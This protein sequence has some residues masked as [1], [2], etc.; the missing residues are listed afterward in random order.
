MTLCDVCQEYT[1]DQFLDEASIEHR[2]FGELFSTSKDCVLCRLILKT[3]RQRVAEST[4]SEEEIEK[5]LATLNTSRISLR[6]PA[7][8][9]TKSPRDRLYIDFNGPRLMIDGWLVLSASDTSLRLIREPGEHYLEF[10]RTLLTLVI[11]GSPQVRDTNIPEGQPLELNAASDSLKK[12]ISGWLEECNQLHKECHESSA[13]EGEVSGKLPV[14]VLDLGLPHDRCEPRLL[15]EH[16]FSSPYVALSHCW[17]LSR[18]IV[19]DTTNLELH[20]TR[21]PYSCLPKTFQDAILLTKSIGIRY[22]WIDSLCI[23]QDNIQDW[24]NEAAKMA[25]VYGNAYCTIAATG[26]HGD[27]E[28]VFIPRA[29]Q[30]VCNLKYGESNTKILVTSI[31]DDIS[32]LK[33]LH[34]DSPL[35]NR[36]WTLQEKLLSR[37]I[38]HFT[39]SRA[40]WECRTRFETED[41]LVLGPDDFGGILTRNIFEFST[42]R[43]K[44]LES[45]K[46]VGQSRGFSQ[47]SK[48]YAVICSM[49]HSVT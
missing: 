10:W 13:V 4:Q 46:A 15:E 39:R 21:I 43:S 3:V 37:R 48:R 9:D 34:S 20:K 42:N 7:L 19:T 12:I 45:L 36:A 24:K 16:G 27:Q 5:H 44:W 40:I 26:S 49:L 6:F 18:H 30:D 28:G 17:G 47:V 8:H 29:E 31:E 14:R 25:D 35:S 38:I 22:L 23:I 32:A 2:L 1:L 33:E 11:I 41:L